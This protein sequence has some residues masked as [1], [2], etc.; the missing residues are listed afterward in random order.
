[1][2]SFKT[3]LLIA[4]FFTTKL[5][6]AAGPKL[7]QIE[8]VSTAVINDSLR[9]SVHYR[10][11]CNCRFI[12]LLAERVDDASTQEEDISLGIIL[13]KSDLDCQEPVKVEKSTF[14]LPAVSYRFHTGIN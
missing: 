6:W 5:S 7:A 13:H 1:M 2:Q 4:F 8:S 9:V 14:T 3:V 11:P 12:K 10:V